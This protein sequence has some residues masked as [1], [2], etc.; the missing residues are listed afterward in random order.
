MAVIDSTGHFYVKFIEPKRVVNKN[1]VL[2]AGIVYL[3][4]SRGLYEF[5]WYIILFLK[6]LLVER[7]SEILFWI[8]KNINHWA[9]KFLIIESFNHTSPEAVFWDV[10]NAV[11]YFPSV[12]LHLDKA[13]KWMW[14]RFHTHWCWKGSFEQ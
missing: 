2:I 5:L 4:R 6:I 7:F 12:H 10:N 1:F 9:P 14:E 3:V 11:N 8:L 13:M